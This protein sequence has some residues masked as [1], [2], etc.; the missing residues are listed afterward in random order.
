MS[1]IISLKESDLIK[2]IKRVIT[3]QNSQPIKAEFWNWQYQ[4]NTEGKNSLGIMEIKN[5]KLVNNIVEFDFNLVGN[6]DL[7]KG[8][9]NCGTKISY[10]EF[11]NPLTLGKIQIKR[12]KQNIAF[13]DEPTK[14]LSNFCKV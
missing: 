6:Q 9:Y 7:H 8:Y 11:K 5:P 4:V 2:I 1:K 10:G 13:R 14:Y 12:G 3:E